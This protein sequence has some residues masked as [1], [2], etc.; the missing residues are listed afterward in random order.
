[1]GNSLVL[2]WIQ[3]SSFH[4]GMMYLVFSCMYVYKSY[5]TDGIGDWIVN[6]ELSR[7]AITI[8]FVLLFGACTEW[9]G[10]CPQWVGLSTA[11][12]DSLHTITTCI[13]NC[14]VSVVH[15]CDSQCGL[16]EQE[17]IKGRTRIGDTKE[18]CVCTKQTTICTVLIDSV[19]IVSHIFVL[20]WSSTNYGVCGRRIVKK[21]SVSTKQ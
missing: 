16:A 11:N 21:C 17:N 9:N 8:L 10:T 5:L 12:S 14:A 4:L 6:R 15:Q 20:V 3:F 18:N 2:H 19:C 13:G 7:R 1:M